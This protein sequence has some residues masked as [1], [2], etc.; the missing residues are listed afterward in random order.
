[1]KQIPLVFIVVSD[2]NKKYYKKTAFNQRD[3]VFKLCGTV[4]A[5][6]F[7]PA[8]NIRKAF[9]KLKEKVTNASQDEWMTY[10]SDRWISSTHIYVEG[11]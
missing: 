9:E 2:K 11:F 1:M 4:F 3:T 5:L 7:L 8:E 6:P 10:I